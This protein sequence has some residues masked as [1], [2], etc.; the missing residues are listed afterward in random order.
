MVA[1]VDVVL[2]AVALRRVRNARRGRVQT[3]VEMT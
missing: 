2:A 1:V 3:A